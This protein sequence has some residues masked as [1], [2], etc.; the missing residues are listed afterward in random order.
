MEKFIVLLIIF[1]IVVICSILILFYNSKIIIESLTTDNKLIMN[2][3]S[4]ISSMY[5]DPEIN[6]V[7]V[8]VI[9]IQG[10]NN[11]INV[12]I[13]DP[14]ENEIIKSTNNGDSNE[15]RFSI[16]KKGMYK[17]KITNTSGKVTQINYAL[18][19]MPNE[20]L[21]TFGIICFYTIVIGLVGIIICCILL[22]RSRRDNG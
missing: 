18:G 4:L 8:Y 16:N 1:C 5:L 12:S 19:Y 22:I 7:G 3:D 14:Y 13:L 15:E 6:K 2:N 21:F 9:Q 17:I 11:Q 10:Q 20:L